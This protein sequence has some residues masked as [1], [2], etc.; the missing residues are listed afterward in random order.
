MKSSGGLSWLRRGTYFDTDQATSLDTAF[1]LP[2]QCCGK[3]RQDDA[4]TAA[5]IKSPAH[6]RELL[7]L[8][9]PRRCGA[10]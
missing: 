5:V 10:R 7:V 4:K 2:R 1:E 9:V 6:Y 3:G 8:I